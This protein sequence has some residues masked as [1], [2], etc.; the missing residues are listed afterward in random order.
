MVVSCFNFL[1]KNRL[2]E[3][4]V[5][6]SLTN[7]LIEISSDLYSELFILSKKQKN[8]SESNFDANILKILKDHKILVNEHD[9]DSF[10]LQK[11]YLNYLKSFKNDFLGL[12]IAPTLNCNF[13]CPYCYENSIQQSTADNKTLRDIVDFIYNFKNI[14]SLSICWHGGEPLLAFDKMLFFLENLYTRKNKLVITHSLITNGYLLSNDKIEELR[15]YKLNYVQ[16]TIDGPPEHHNH[17]RPLKSGMPTYDKIISNIDN[18]LQKNPEI[19]VNVRINVHKDNRN[20]FSEIYKTLTSRWKGHN[21]RISLVFVSDNDNC[22]VPC[23]KLHDRFNF[24][25]ELSMDKDL[26]KINFFPENQVYGCTATY[27]NSF[28]IGPKGEFYKCW[29]DIGNEERI[30]GSIY[31]GLT[32]YSLIAEYMV[33]SD[34]FSDEKCLKCFLFP[35]C[36]GVCNLIRFENKFRNE[37]AEN[38]PIDINSFAEILSLHQKQTKSNV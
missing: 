24:L 30:I 21:Y 6:N 26:P 11:K 34:M 36:N 28:V 12:V 25:K 16:I 9:D 33:G 22:M 18:I 8:V 27:Q 32:N 35:I 3:N 23:M 14:D 37:K 10:I 19:T 13:A 1:F 4:F 38:C 31:E 29:A 7:S 15:K 5:Y 17:N 2:N 20:S